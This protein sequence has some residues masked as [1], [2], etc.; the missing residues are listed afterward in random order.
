[1]VKVSQDIST[2]IM[3]KYFLSV[4]EA[5]WLLDTYSAGNYMFKVKNRNTRTR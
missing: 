5:M 4:F 1:M 3:K 2:K